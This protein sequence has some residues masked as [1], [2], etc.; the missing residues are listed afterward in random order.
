VSGGNGP[1]WEVNMG[2]ASR[3]PTKGRD[4]PSKRVGRRL[5]YKAILY[6]TRTGPAFGTK[7]LRRKN[8]QRTN[9]THKSDV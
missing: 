9:P 3:S 4:E 7:N 6:C 5:P 2:K 1:A 8:I